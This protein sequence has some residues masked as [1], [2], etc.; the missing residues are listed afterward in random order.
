VRQINNNPLQIIA[1]FVGLE[2]SLRTIVKINSNLKNVVKQLYIKQI[3]N[4][5]GYKKILIKYDDSH[6]KEILFFIN[7]LKIKM[8][9]GSSL[10]N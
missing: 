10:I 5:F 3:E 1:E 7:Y 8:K 4:L 6:V 9:I 2:V